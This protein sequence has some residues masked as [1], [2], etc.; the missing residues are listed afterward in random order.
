MDVQAS[1]F[2]TIALL[3]LLEGLLSADNALVLAI[4]VLG[5]PRADQRKALRYGIIG[6]FA[7]RILATLLAVQLIAFGWVKLVG[8][9]YLLYLAFKHFFGHGGTAERRSIPQARA[10]FG[11]SAFWA[12]VVKVELT[13]IVFAIDSI[14]VAV[15]MS[16]KTWVIIAGGIFGIV[17]MRLVIGQLLTIVRRYPALVDGAFIIIAWVGIKLLIEYLHL[18]GHIHFQVNKWMSFGLI[19]L[20]FLASYL[21]AR[22]QGPVP[23][24]GGQRDEA[25]ELFTDGK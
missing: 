3:V 15:A 7:F 14:L 2:F 24:D 8:A 18:E 6:A 20:I 21:Y 25:T 5:L 1:D 22:R 4:L 9:A 19:V 16:S 12:T 10:A 23:D 13:D 11:L 17:A